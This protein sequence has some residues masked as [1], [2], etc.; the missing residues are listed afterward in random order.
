MLGAILEMRDYKDFLKTSCRLL[1]ANAR[2]ELYHEISDANY[3]LLLQD[4]WEEDR[5]I[6]MVVGEQ[7]IVQSLGETEGDE[8]PAKIVHRL[9]L[10]GK[11]N[12]GLEKY[13][14]SYLSRACV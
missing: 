9:Q 7:S 6:P 10:L 4:L 1:T 2:S 11:A 14:Y 5:L 12:P 13:L 3:V 8:I